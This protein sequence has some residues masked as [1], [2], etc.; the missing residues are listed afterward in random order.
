MEVAGAQVTA[1]DTLRA[2]AVVEQIADR[3]EALFD[4]AAATRVRSQWNLAADELDAARIESLPWGTVN[5]HI[6]QFLRVASDTRDE[7]AETASW[8]VLTS[9]R[10]VD[11]TAGTRIHADWVRVAPT[12]PLRVPGAAESH[13]GEGEEEAEY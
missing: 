7:D 12:P 10:N 5:G 1:E 9:L 2:G 4:Q 6:R 3:A 11:A 13:V 8:S